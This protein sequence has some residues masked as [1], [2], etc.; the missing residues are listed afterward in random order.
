VANRKYKLSSF[1]LMSSLN[2]CFSVYDEKYSNTYVLDKRYKW[3][4]ENLKFDCF[5]L[6]ELCNSQQES[7]LSSEELLSV[8]EQFLDSNIVVQIS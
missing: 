6:E 4:L 2:D 5:L 8:I 1:V 3:I 7:Q